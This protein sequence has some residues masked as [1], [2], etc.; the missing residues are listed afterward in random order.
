MDKKGTH[1][2]LL[3]FL[4]KRKAEQDKHR[5]TQTNKTVKTDKKTDKDTPPR[6][7]INSVFAKHQDDARAGARA[8]ARGEKIDE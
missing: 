1:T 7:T 2:S 6:V 4:Y 5:D 8:L 3:N